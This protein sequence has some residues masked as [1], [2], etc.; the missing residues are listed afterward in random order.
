MVAGDGMKTAF[1]WNIAPPRTDLGNGLSLTTFADSTA[2]IGTHYLGAI[3]DMDYIWWAVGQD[4][5][6]TVT[7]YDCLIVSLFGDMQHI[8]QIKA[9]HPN[10][11]VIAL[12]D[13][14][15]DDMFVNYSVW[16]MNM[17]TQLQA[18]D[19]IG[20][21]SESNRQFY[22]AI[23]HEKPTV[24]IPMPIGTD[25]FFQT[26]RTQPKEDFIITSDH[27]NYLG[28]RPLDYSMPN[29]AAVAAIQRATGLRVVYVNAAKK[30]PE[31]AKFAGLEATFTDYLNFASYAELA[32]RA[33]LGVDMYCL[34]G[35]GR[36]TL[37]YAAAGTPAFGSDYNE[38]SMSSCDPWNPLEAVEVVDNYFSFPTY[39]EMS[40]R[41]G[42]DRV[43]EEHTFAACRKQMTAVLEQVEQWRHLPQP[44]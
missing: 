35:F 39:Y 37:M 16:D 5:P 33:R 15:F 30:T 24:K 44:N 2:L 9:I 10:C 6:E 3:C 12:P 19:C 25:G 41:H 11:Y 22:G 18:A 20:Y 36:N 14:Y 1:V 42:L 43:Y 28:E 13:A 26:V 32:A 34:H 29:V 8:T 23:F 40:R 7:D 4:A 31:Y 27:G 17:L 21:V 38:F